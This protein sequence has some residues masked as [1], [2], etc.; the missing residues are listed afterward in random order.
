MRNENIR[1]EQGTLRSIKKIKRCLNIFKAARNINIDINIL[2]EILYLPSTFY[3]D[4]FFE[5]SYQKKIFKYFLYIKKRKA[6]SH[7]DNVIIKPL[8]K[9][10]KYSHSLKKNLVTSNK[11]ALKNDSYFP[12]LL[13]CNFYY[14]K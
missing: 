13:F 4:V 9:L 12:H 14:K 8:E 11:I 1:A 6:F 5:L 3:F 7:I 10:L 2:Q